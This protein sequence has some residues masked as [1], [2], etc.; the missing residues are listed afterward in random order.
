MHNILKIALLY[1]LCVLI[2]L[3]LITSFKELLEGLSQVTDVS[4]HIVYIVPIHIDY[5]DLFYIVF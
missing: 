5:I 3:Y 2:F 4:A 1:Y